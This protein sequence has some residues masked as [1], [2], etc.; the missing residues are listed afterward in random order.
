MTKTTQAAGLIVAL[1]L[2]WSF[3]R[4]QEAEKPESGD[5]AVGLEYLELY[6]AG[7]IE[8]MRPF[9]TEA[10]VFEDPTAEAMG[11]GF[12]LTGADQIVTQLS[13]IFDAQKPE[14]QPVFQFESGRFAVSAGSFVYELPG[15]MAGSDEESVQI[16]L[17]ITSIAEFD[18][19][20]VVRHTDYGDYAGMMDG[21]SKSKEEDK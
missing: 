21:L 1:A 15:S 17:S 9:F 19:G 3:A 5:E 6:H 12:R 2:G 10:S 20:K 7:K 16:E 11:S 18:G 8:Q 14:Y 4:V 13:E